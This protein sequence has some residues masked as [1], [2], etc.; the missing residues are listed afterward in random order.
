MFKIRECKKL[1]KKCNCCGKIKN[2][3]HF[4]K[5]KDCVDGY[6]NKCKECST[7]IYIYTCQYCGKEFK[8]DSKKPK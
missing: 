4:Q 3:H 2:I 6:R 7:K 8:G 5:Q 1:M